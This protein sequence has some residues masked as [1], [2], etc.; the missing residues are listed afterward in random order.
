MWMIQKWVTTCSM[1]YNMLVEL[2]DF[3]AKMFQKTLD[4]EKEA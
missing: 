3:Q 1:L 4:M 2:K